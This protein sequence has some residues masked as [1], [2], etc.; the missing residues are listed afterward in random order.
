MRVI[1]YA[2][3]QPC[4][5]ELATH[6]WQGAKD[7][8]HKLFGWEMADMAMPG[9]AFSMFTLDG[10]DLGAI[11]Q[12][13]SA[14]A[15]SV[16]TQ[17]GIYFATED[18][19]AAIERVKA[20]G[21]ELIMGPH[22]VGHAGWMAQLADPEGARFAVW[23]SKRHIG[24]KRRGEPGA[25]CWVE[26]ACRSPSRAQGFYSKVFGWDCRESANEDMPYR[27]WLV[28]DEALGGMLEMTAE[29]GE[30]PAHWMLYFQVVDCDV[31]AKRAQELGG[32]LCV[33]PTNIPGVGRFAVLNDP[34]GGVFSVI[35]IHSA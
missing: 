15:G 6:D 17:W 26:L 5:S 16:K 23:Q 24:A 35:A 27:E 19:N 34:D 4:W 1:E 13:P 18:V 9:S 12:V 20:A 30:M 2:P 29:W 21:G 28:A 31:F 22:E 8:Y 3:G 11:Y 32:T 25:L 14:L 33:P 10:D 7:F